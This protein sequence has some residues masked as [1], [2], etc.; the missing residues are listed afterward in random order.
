[1][2]GAA[3]NDP[4][5]IEWMRDLEAEPHRFGFIA[6]LRKLECLYDD[7]PRLGESP[8]AADDAV[9][10]GQDPSLA[11]APRPIA[12]FKAG[13]QSTP[14]RLNTFFFGLF[15]PNGPMPLHLSEFVHSRDLNDGDRTF[16][17]FADLFHHRLLSLFYRASVN[18]E[19][20]INLDRRDENR[21]DMFI[22]AFLGVGPEEFRDRDALPH[23]AKL[24]NAAHLAMQTRPADAFVDL[25]ENFFELP[26]ALEQLVGEWLT[27]ADEDVTRLGVPSGACILG[28]SAILGKEIW[29]C[30]HRFR[31]VCGP[32][33]LD[34]FN[35]LLP[36]ESG[37]SA[38]E[39]AVRNFAGD[40]YAWDVKL[41]LRK[42]DVPGINLGE[43]G[44]LGWTSWLGERQQSTDADDVIIDLQRMGV[45]NRVT[46]LHA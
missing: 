44:Q 30:Q 37:V 8:R 20:T 12:G 24:H 2:A 1:M 29:S 27:L 22:G 18:G 19:P 21:F 41:V 33:S 32:L 5:A 15:G 31:V 38:L 10:L 23:S 42:E 34:E 9:R 28:G 35:R 14:D 36:G 11:F 17:A 3:R 26:F 13:T 45:A 25:L 39:A 43:T 4:H 40:E 16:R 7:R 6:A 46:D